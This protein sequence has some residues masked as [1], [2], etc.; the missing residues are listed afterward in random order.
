MKNIN[1]I[2]ST[3]PTKKVVLFVPF[4]RQAGHVGNNRID[5]FVR[6]LSEDGYEIVM[7]RAGSKEAERTEVWGKEITIVDRLRLHPETTLSQATAVSPRKPNKLRRALACWLFIPDPIV[8]WARAAARHPRA[9]KAARGAAFI[10]SSSP[11]E[12]A[13]L[14]A[15]LL[16]R[17]TGVPLIMDMRDGWLDEPLNPL[18][19]SSP[20]RRWWEGRLESRIAQH[21]TVIQVTSDAWKEL[22]DRRYPGMIDK[23]HVLTNAYPKDIMRVTQKPPK[24]PDDKYLLIHAGRFTDSHLSRTPKLLLEPLHYKLAVQGLKGVIRFYGD[25]PPAEITSILLFS[26]NYAKIGWSFEFPGAVPRVDMLQ[27]MR[28]ADGLLLLSASHAA[29]PSKM[30][31]YIS[32]G[33]PIIYSSPSGSATWRICS[34]LNNTLFLMNSENDKFFNQ[35]KNSPL[36]SIDVATKSWIPSDCTLP[37]EYSESYLKRKF[38]DAIEGITC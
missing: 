35:S 31:E 3:A 17:R 22:F 19:N 6:W 9:I 36:T 28:E 16:S 30:F 18:L 38:M 14:G 1:A 11:P 13:H 2:D 12:S 26:E 7:I 24:G 23:V 27:I 29:L 15:Y 21:A 10:L 37:F 34:K 5:R 4:W 32:T 33:L 20:L 25:L 8:V